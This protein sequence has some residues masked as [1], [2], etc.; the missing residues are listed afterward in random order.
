MA[1]L[2]VAPSDVRRLETKGDDMLV[3]CFPLS[4]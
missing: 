1:A 2:P 3:K 4:V